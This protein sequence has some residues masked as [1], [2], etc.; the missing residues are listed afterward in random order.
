MLDPFGTKRYAVL[1]FLRIYKT[2]CDLNSLHE[3]LPISHKA[4][5]VLLFS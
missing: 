5:G 4:L 3:L 1:R 2:D